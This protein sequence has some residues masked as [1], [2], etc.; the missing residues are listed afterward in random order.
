MMRTRLLIISV[1]TLGLTACDS[2]GDVTDDA[3]TEEAVI[4][5]TAPADNVMEPMAETQEF[6]V[7][8]G[9]GN[10]YPSE[11]AARD[12]GL[13]EAEYGATYCEM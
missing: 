3:T 2:G 10:R 6:E 1:A 7:C 5:E 4:E 9:D 8:D 13:S 11:Q 12:A